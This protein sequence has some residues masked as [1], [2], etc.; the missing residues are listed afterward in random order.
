MSFF[1]I[2]STVYSKITLNAFKKL[3]SNLSGKVLSTMS[4]V[5]LLV[6][7]FRLDTTTLLFEFS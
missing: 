5:V 4:E 3:T 1:R 2:K 6:E 7:I